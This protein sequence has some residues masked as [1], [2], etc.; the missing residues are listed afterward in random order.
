MTEPTKEQVW[1]EEARK[2]Y[3]EQQSQDNEGGCREP[4]GF[5]QG[6]ISAKK[7][8]LKEIESLKVNR[9]LQRGLF[10][11]ELFLKQLVTENQYHEICKAFKLPFNDELT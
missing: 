10:I 5:V 3:Q 7:S 8:D 9:D 11:D 4:I 6:Y 1:K 2:A